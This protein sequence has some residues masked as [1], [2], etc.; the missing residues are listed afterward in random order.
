MVGLPY[1][2]AVGLYAEGQLRSKTEGMYC[3]TSRAGSKHLRGHELT[4]WMLYWRSQVTLLF[5]STNAPL[6][7]SRQAQ[8]CSS[9]NAGKP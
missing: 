4:S 6:G 8:T 3:V 5:Q 1:V 7:L 2:S 9:K